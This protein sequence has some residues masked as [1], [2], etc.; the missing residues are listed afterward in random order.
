MIEANIQ[1]PPSQ[2]IEIREFRGF[3][4]S[5]CCPPGW[6]NII[7]NVDLE[8]DGSI[9]S[10]WGSEILCPNAPLTS[11]GNVRINHLECF[12][13]KLLV[14]QEK[15]VF[16]KTDA[17]AYEEITGPKGGDLLDEALPDSCSDSDFWNDHLIITG[18]NCSKPKK[19]YCDENGNLTA[20]SLG[21]PAV[22]VSE[23]N[24]SFFEV[25]QPLAGSVNAIGDVP[26][27]NFIIAFFYCCRYVNEQGVEFLDFGPVT[28]VPMPSAFVGLGAAGSVSPALFVGPSLAIVDPLPVPE[29][30]C[31]DGSQYDEMEVKL[32]V[33]RTAT[34][35]ST[36][37]KLGEY[38]NNV[39][40]IFYTT[41]GSATAGG[42]TSEDFF[43]TTEEVTENGTTYLKFTDTIVNNQVIYNQGSTIEWTP[44]PYSEFVEVIDEIA[45]YAG[46]TCVDGETYDNRLYQSIPGAPGSVPR[47]YFV[48]FDGR[49]NGLS[50]YSRFPIVSVI[51][52]CGD[53]KLYRVQG[54]LDEFG[55]DELIPNI[56]AD[57]TAAIN[58]NSFVRAESGLYFL[59]TGGSGVYRTDGYKVEKVT[60][61]KCNFDETYCE[62]I[63]E[64]YQRKNIYGTYD[65]YRNRIYWGVTSTRART[66][67][68]KYLVYHESRNAFTW[69]TNGE[70]FKPS[71]SIYDYEEKALIRGDARGYVFQHQDGL[72]SDPTVDVGTAAANWGTSLVPF[73]LK[74]T[75]ID[76]GD[77]S[78]NKQ[79][80][81]IYFH[82]KPE[83]NSTFKIES[84]DNGCDTPKTL[85]LVEFEY[86]D[87]CHMYVS[88]RFACSRANVKSKQIK[89]SSSSSVIEC[90]TEPAD[91]IIYEPMEN[92]IARQ[93][94]EPFDNDDIG[95]TICI[96]GQ[97]VEI[98]NII[99]GGKAEITLAPKPAAGNYAWALKG[100]DKQDRFCINCI[101]MTFCVIGDVGGEFTAGSSKT[102]QWE[103]FQNG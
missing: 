30:T 95:N 84:F 33:Y 78:K 62:L 80:S 96:E 21:L 82:G 12:K 29:F 70:N 49:I 53:C 25:T 61:P 71:A 60:D 11:L 63:E 46:E 31:P 98:T 14:F 41:N 39:G 87:G 43:F 27:Q 15:K 3:T 51:D 6:F 57:R 94:A 48:E 28:Y 92:S 47:S 13:G 69:H 54:R 18:G 24:T 55:R 72:T 75:E 23:D 35:S 10:R 52:D 58:N 77:C 36:F 99:F 66:E 97:E 17:G 37:Y 59:G 19:I 81:K 100:F 26:P 2:T 79:V 20:K 4:D 89:L 42:V 91:F 67:N 32:H 83:A 90:G 76:F 86:N 101:G 64:E 34:N 7:D 22:D 88:R 8:D 85:N 73:C 38:E 44:A 9:C 93:S 65:K 102:A 56:I 103:A 74:T 68:D 5:E 50:Q 1:V 40:S 16:C 45:W